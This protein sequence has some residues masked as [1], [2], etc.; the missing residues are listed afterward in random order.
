MTFL[1]LIAVIF[2]AANLVYWKGW[3]YV[4]GKAN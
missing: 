3:G 4:E 1:I 2:I